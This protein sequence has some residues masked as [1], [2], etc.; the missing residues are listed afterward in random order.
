MYKYS[1]SVA[2]FLG[3]ALTLFSCSYLNPL[4][5]SEVNPDT[6][7]GFTVYTIP[8]NQHNTSNNIGEV[9]SSKIKFIAKFDNSAIYTTTDKINQADINKLYGFSDC[10]SMHQNNSARFGWRWYQNKLE[11][12]AYTYKNKKR[13][14]K[15]IQAIELNKEYVFELEA[16][17]NKYVFKLEDKV[18]E[19]PRGCSGNYLKYKLFPYFGGDEVAPHKIRIFIKDLN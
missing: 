16:A 2:K 14:V 3:L 4:G 12:F 8:Q 17:N 15:L 7:N 19:M 13:E 9:A 5:D 1:S 10:N 6:G 11:I 18:I